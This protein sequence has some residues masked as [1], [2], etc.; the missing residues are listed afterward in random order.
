MDREIGRSPYENP[1]YRGPECDG[2]D[3]DAA[4]DLAKQLRIAARNRRIAQ[5]LGDERVA[6]QKALTCW[7]VGFGI[8]A[9]MAGLAFTIW[10]VGYFG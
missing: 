2:L 3:E 1:L 4:F 9:I 5:K 7:G 6:R 10:A 8:A